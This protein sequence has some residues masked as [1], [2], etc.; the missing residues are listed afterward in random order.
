MVKDPDNKLDKNAY[1]NRDTR[2][3]VVFPRIG[4]FEIYIYNVLIYSKFMTNNWPNHYKLIQIITKI[5]EAKKKGE[6]LE[7]YSVYRFREE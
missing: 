3:P 4:A 2:D 7:E 1:I 6:S 5:I